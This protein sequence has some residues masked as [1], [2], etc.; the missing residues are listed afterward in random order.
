MD[1]ITLIFLSIGLAMDCFVVSIA[2]AGGI[3]RLKWGGVMF[4]A[5]MF[6]LFQSIM[7]LI[8]YYLGNEFI[9]IIQ[10]Y[11]HWIAFVILAIIGGRMVWED[12]FGKEEVKEGED[13]VNPYAI[14]TVLM[15]S[16]A[17][18]I[19]AL[20]TG[21]VFLTEPSALVKGIIIIGAGSFILSIVGSIVGVY[22]SKNLKFKFGALGGI[23]LIAIGVKIVIE[24][25]CI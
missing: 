11:D 19:D 17:T 4:M 1:I 21:L 12:F 10:D 22:A 9:D 2:T 18:S 6:G 13:S 16:V 3:G 5:I 23:I 25:C 24:H 8:G 15:L 14:G 7:P 20:A